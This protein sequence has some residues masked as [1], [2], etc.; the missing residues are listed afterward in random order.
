MEGFSFH[1]NFRKSF[2]LPFAETINNRNRVTSYKKV[3]KVPPS[4]ST[5]HI[6]IWGKKQKRN[7]LKTGGGG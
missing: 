3:P 1:F 2:L 5:P 4:L 6:S 7:I